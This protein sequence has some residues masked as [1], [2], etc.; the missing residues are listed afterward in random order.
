MHKGL[1]GSELLKFRIADLKY[2]IHMT[3]LICHYI[4]VI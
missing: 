3:L 4:V 2:S 1:L